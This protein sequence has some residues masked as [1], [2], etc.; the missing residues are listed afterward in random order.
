MK[1][2]IIKFGGFVKSHSIECILICA[3]FL[4]PCAIEVQV[5]D[6]KKQIA[7][8]VALSYQAW[9]KESGNPKGL[10]LDEY[11]VSKYSYFNSFKRD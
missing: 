9:C 11:R 6:C 7:K 5:N 10:T 4:L 1:P 3:I 2:A 8:D